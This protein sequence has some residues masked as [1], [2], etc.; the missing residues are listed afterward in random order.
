MILAS[1]YI[2]PV[3]GV[4]DSDPPHEEALD[5]AARTARDLGLD[6]L[7]L[8]VPE[9]ALLGPSRDVVRYLDG[10]VR[11]L[12]R[13]HENRLSA[14][15]VFPAFRFLGLP[16]VPPYLARAGV[17]E[18][19]EPVFVDG[20]IRRLPPY[21]WWKDLA[22]I[23]KRVRLAR[24]IAAAL[25]G[26]PGLSGWRIMDG[27]LSWSRPD[28]AAA[29]FFFRAVAAEIRDRDDR[30][31]I[32]LRL[33]WRELGRPAPARSL[34]GKADGIHL[35]GLEQP[36]RDVHAPGDRVLWAAYA[37]GIARWLFGGPVETDLAPPSG[38]GL[39]MRKPKPG[40]GSGNGLR[41]ARFCPR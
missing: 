18:D 38:S 27:L 30:A 25:S 13:V 41:K 15:I 5:R 35:T 10:Q 9:E 39:R 19:A 32:V 6:R 34:A 21:E 16:F 22:I 36:P 11:A 1:H 31:R 24:E 40:T 17:D 23:E 3:R 4:V 28:D 37:G 29:D 14:D 2:C 33:N 12:D 8:P 26:H 20:H 7:L